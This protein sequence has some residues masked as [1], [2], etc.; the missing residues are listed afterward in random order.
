MNTSLEQRLSFIDLCLYFYGR[1]SRNILIEY[2]Q[3]GTA[4]SSRTFK[5]YMDR[6]PDNVRLLQGKTGGYVLTEKFFPM[7]NHQSESALDLLSSGKITK[8]L[9][10]ETYGPNQAVF[11]ATL[12]SEIVAPITR[13]M[14][15]QTAVSITYASGTSGYSQT[16]V[17]PKHLFQGGGAW[18]YRAF[19][20]LHKEYRTFRFSR[21]TSANSVKGSIFQRVDK[22]WN[23][24]VILSV[25]P[26]NRHPNPEAHAMDLGMCNRPVINIKTNKVVAG[27]ILTDF[28]VDCSL[29]GE[30]DP[31]EYPLRLMNRNELLDVTSMT[32]APGFRKDRSF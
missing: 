14:V 20:E 24:F 10:I 28:R 7:F 8:H 16:I 27:F 18:Y 3:I 15:S 31:Y 32:I 22:Q 25:A 1:V 26:H 29:Y 17:H 23:E 19:D 5:E 2:F 21:T 13:A 30:L 6:W 12:D 4:T 9:S 11:S